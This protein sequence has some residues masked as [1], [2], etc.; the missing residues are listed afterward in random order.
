MDKGS[1][2]W[3][4]NDVIFIRSSSS[5]SMHTPCPLSSSCIVFCAWLYQ[6]LTHA[7]RDGWYTGLPFRAHSLLGKTYRHVLSY[8]KCQGSR[9]EREAPFPLLQS[10]LHMVT[11]SVFPRHN[12]NPE[13]QRAPI[14]H[15]DGPW[16]QSLLSPG[17]LLAV[18]CCPTTS[19]R[20][21]NLHPTLCTHWP[22]SAFHFSASACL[23]ILFP[24][25]QVSSAQFSCSVVSNSLQPTDCRTPG[26]PI[27][28]QL[29]ELA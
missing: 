21:S 20:F 11:R 24:L 3:I 12:S 27:H 6:L 29:L 19:L 13:S 26:L 1:S 10:S 9:G 5:P 14:S 15:G 2:N 4:Q 16:F 28:H 23:F 18:A 7:A 17:S 8:T 25:S 22:E